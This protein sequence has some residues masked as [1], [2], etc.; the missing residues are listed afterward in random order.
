MSSRPQCQPTCVWVSC[1]KLGSARRGQ[2]RIVFDLDDSP[3]VSQLYSR[4]KGTYF[5]MAWIRRSYLSPQ[6]TMAIGKLSNG[7]KG[8]SGAVAA[9]SNRPRNDFPVWPYSN[10]SICTSRRWP[11]V[12]ESRRSQRFRL[13]PAR[14]HGCVSLIRPELQ[15]AKSRK[16]V[17]PVRALRSIRFSHPVTLTSL[18]PNVVGPRRGRN[19]R[20]PMAMINAMNDRGRESAG[21]ARPPT[22]SRDDGPAPPRRRGS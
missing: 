17:H 10:S 2:N 11:L 3:A 14:Y 13:F 9:A 12:R 18:I 21:I 8:A 15:K 22:G 5:R 16:I 19:Q 6:S 20:E 7:I 1:R 4:L